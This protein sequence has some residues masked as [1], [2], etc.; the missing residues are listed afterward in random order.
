MEK[1]S[2]NATNKI[3]KTQ[4]LGNDKNLSKKKGIL[5]SNSKTILPLKTPENGNSLAWKNRQDIL[6]AKSERAK[7]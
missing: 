4:I 5:K 7:K 3:S 1:N 2:K 6:L